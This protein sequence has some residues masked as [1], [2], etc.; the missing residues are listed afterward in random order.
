MADSLHR[1]TY[2]M[3]T[4]KV[5][6]L[7]LLPYTF[8]NTMPMTITL[9][10]VQK[11]VYFLLALRPGMIRENGVVLSFSTGQQQWH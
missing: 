8:C 10:P 11:K 2:V 4:R 7:Q 5:H 3:R 1:A 6:Q 9:L